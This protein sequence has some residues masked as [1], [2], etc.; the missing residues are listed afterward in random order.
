MRT[1]R[2]VS[3]ALVALS[4]AAHAQIQTFDVA[5]VVP[6]QGGGIDFRFDPNRVV[7]TNVTL[8]Q[9]IEQAYGLRFQEIVGGPDWIR[10]ERYNVIATAGEAR[11]DRARLQAM[12]RTLL[13]DRFQLRLAPETQTGTV[14]TLTTRNVKGLRPPAQADARPLVSVSFDRSRGV[15]SY[16]YDGRNATMA[17][18]AETLAGHVRAPVTDKTGINGSYD[19]SVRWAPDGQA[20]GLDPDPDVPQIFTALD[21]ELGLKLESGRGPVPVHVVKRAEKPSAN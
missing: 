11:V 1:L 9:L 2:N 17:M 16:S 19:F 4:A 21:L 13:E 7:A 8:T 12:L 5:S 10:T 18:L 15:I 14:Y 3:L 20:Q 6:A